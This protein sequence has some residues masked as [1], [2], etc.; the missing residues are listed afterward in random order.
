MC[1]L[2]KHFLHS[3]NLNHISGIS[4]KDKGAAMT[5]IFQEAGLGQIGRNPKE[6]VIIAANT[7]GRV[8]F[9]KK[10]GQ[11]RDRK[12]DFPLVIIK[13]LGKT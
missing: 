9:H 6:E 5:L 12:I 2:K 8:L 7:N 13:K 1:K 3:N 10:V 4:N 11:S